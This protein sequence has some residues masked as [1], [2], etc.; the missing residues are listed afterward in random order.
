MTLLLKFSSPEPPI[1]PS[2]NSSHVPP[3]LFL[4]LMSSFLLLLLY[5]HIVEQKYK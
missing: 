1:F 3:S 2:I 5:Q 4:K